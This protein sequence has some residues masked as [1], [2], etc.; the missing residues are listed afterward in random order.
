MCVHSAWSI[1]RGAHD[2][3]ESEEDEEIWCITLH[4]AIAGMQPGEMVDADVAARITF[5]EATADQY[6]SGNRRGRRI[7]RWIEQH[8]QMLRHRHPS[9]PLRTQPDQ[10]AITIRPGVTANVI[11]RSVTR[12]G[13]EVFLSPQL[14]KI[15][16]RIGL[17]KCGA[18]PAQLF[19]S[20]YA[21]DPNGGPLTGRKAMC[22]QRAN[23]NKK[24]VPLGLRITSAGAGYRDRPYTLSLWL[25]P[26]GAQWPPASD[27][28]QILLSD[29]GIFDPPTEE[30]AAD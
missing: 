18:T 1:G 15:F 30:P 7:I 22:V 29:F 21:D 28:Q 27:P 11:H 10:D 12:D 17:S 16:L 25:R 6:Y 14:F 3:Q 2:H 5:W 26:A 8:V 20:I 9:I 24:L 19:Q 4:Q 13:V 23:L